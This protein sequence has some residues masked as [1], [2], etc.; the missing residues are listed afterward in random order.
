MVQV[1]MGRRTD[2]W[3]TY[4]HR[5]THSAISIVSDDTRVDRIDRFDHRDMTLVSAHMAQ[6]HKNYSLSTTFN[7]FQLQLI[8][9]D[10]VMIIWDNGILREKNK[11][12]QQYSS[13]LNPFMPSGFFYHSS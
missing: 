5:A 12:K 1:F 10:D 11:T 13:Y 4:A 2:V 3:Q 9:R 6:K 8:S 7:E